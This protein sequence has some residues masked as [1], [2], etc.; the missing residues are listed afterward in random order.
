M[1]EL[2]GTHEAI[3]IIKRADPRGNYAKEWRP[4]IGRSFARLAHCKLLRR[5]ARREQVHLRCCCKASSWTELGEYLSGATS[6]S[7]CV[8]PKSVDRLRKQASYVPRFPKGAEDSCTCS[9]P[10]AINSAATLTLLHHSGSHACSQNEKP[11]HKNTRERS[12]E[13]AVC[14]APTCAAHMDSLSSVF[15]HTTSK[16]CLV[17]FSSTAANTRGVSGLNSS[18]GAFTMASP[19]PAANNTKRNSALCAELVSPECETFRNFRHFSWRLWKPPGSEI[20]SL[21]WLDLKQLQHLIED[22]E[23]ADILNYREPACSHLRNERI[24][25]RTRHERLSS[26]GCV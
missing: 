13:A 3:W 5:P 25:H 11:A 2:S 20:R 15:G 9:H 14:P 23:R 10:S 21:H 16:P 17:S 8:Q 18:S 12:E 24:A 7:A 26:V 22:F 6:E 4:S 19:S 1:T